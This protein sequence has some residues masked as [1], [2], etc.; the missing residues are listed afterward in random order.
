[1]RFFSSN[2]QKNKEQGFTILELLISTAVFSVV[3]LL[4]ATAIVQVGQI[5]YKGVVTNRIQ[6]TSRKVANDVIGAIQY[7]DTNL[8][9]QKVPITG[10]FAECLGTIRYTYL[11]S[12]SVGTGTGQSAHVLWK[13][14]IG[15]SGSCGLNPVN[16]NAPVGQGEELLG[17]NMRVK[18]FTINSLTGST[19]QVTITVAYGATDDVFNLVGG[20][21]D[22]GHCIPRNTGG[23]FCAVSSIT[24]YVTERL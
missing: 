2:G 9:H 19:W 24:S 10:G 6:D 11:L 21:Y 1:M 8:L 13:D 15:A 16:L 20:V 18:D 12:K 22:Y 3:L 4:C 7:G 23:Q 14:R 17:P 5:Y